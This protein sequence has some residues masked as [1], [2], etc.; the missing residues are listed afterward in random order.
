MDKIH[1]RRKG[2]FRISDKEKALRKAKR[3]SEKRKKQLL[4]AKNAAERIF[5]F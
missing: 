2:R 3:N 4:K 5:S 1:K